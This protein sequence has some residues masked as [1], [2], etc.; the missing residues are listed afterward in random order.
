MTN[1]EAF[2]STQDEKDIIEAI[3]NA[4]DKTSGEIRVHIEHASNKA[5][6][7]R[8]LEV[9][10]YL[11]MD[12][13]EQRNG[14]LIYVAIDNRQFIIY[15]DLAINE[16]VDDSFWDTTRDAMQSQFRIGNFKQGLI[17]GILKAGEELKVHFP[18]NASDIDELPNEISKG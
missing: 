6:F 2:L 13:T 15:G 1:L 8:A 3:C 4:E 10:H 14:V 16:K 11:K 5:L 12:E 17:N 7:E 9:F 18:W